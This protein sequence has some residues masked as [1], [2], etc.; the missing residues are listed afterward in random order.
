LLRD[1]GLPDL[2]DDP[3]FAT[4]E[5]IDLNA[6]DLPYLTAGRLTHWAFADLERLVRNKYDGTIVPM[7]SLTQVI[8][9]PQVRHLGIFAD[10]PTI[11]FPMEERT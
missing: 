4:P 7:L 10:G 9:H 3:R 6:T 5:A 2:A 11:R 1:M 8:D